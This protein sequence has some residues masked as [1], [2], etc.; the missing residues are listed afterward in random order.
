MSH[1][2]R[3]YIFFQGKMRVIIHFVSEKPSLHYRFDATP[4][5]DY[6]YD[7]QPE[8]EEIINM[9][10]NFQ[11][12]QHSLAALKA[13]IQL[14]DQAALELVKSKLTLAHAHAALS[15]INPDIK[16]QAKGMPGLLEKIFNTRGFAS[17]CEIATQAGLP[18]VVGSQNKLAEQKR[19]ARR[20]IQRRRQYEKFEW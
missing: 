9:V 14:R 19:T 3:M 6:N 18:S 5:I 2:T 20:A 8:A 10:D 1:Y 12:P 7:P 17:L 4:G 11:A 15:Q 16:P 13:A